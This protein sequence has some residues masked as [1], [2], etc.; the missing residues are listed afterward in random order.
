MGIVL[1]K[2]GEW[3]QT[4]LWFCLIEYFCRALLITSS[5]VIDGIASFLRAFE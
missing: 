5:G 1:E 2:L 4:I 3:G